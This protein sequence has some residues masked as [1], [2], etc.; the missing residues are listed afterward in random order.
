MAKIRL[1]AKIRR[2][3]RED[4]KTLNDKV[5]TMGSL[6]KCAINDAVR[7]LVDRDVDLA[8]G[9]LRRD[10]EIN[11][12]ELDIEKRCINLIMLQQPMATDLRMVVTSLKIITDL[13]RI[14]DLAAN[15]AQLVREMENEEMVKPLIDIPRMSELAQQMVEMSIKSFTEKDVSL[16]EGL[17]I[18]DDEL[19]ALFDQVFR[20]LLAYMTVDYSAV[21]N[22]YHLLLIARYL[23][24]IGDHACNIGGRVIYMVTGKRRKIA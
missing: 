11:A 24:R 1:T 22:G 19:D 4:L 13:D 14:A 8:A 3:Y 15:I 17:K 23:E 6:V 7:S 16:A 21:P 18:K 10:D 5:R 20:E 2:S 9:V 12:I